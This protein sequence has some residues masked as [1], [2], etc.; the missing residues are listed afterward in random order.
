LL[1]QFLPDSQF[2]ATH[3][4]VALDFSEATDLKNINFV[5]VYQANSQKCNICYFAIWVECLVNV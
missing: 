1:A 3:F 5:G 2:A 4:Q